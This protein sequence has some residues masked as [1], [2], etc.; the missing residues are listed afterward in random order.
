[1]QNNDAAQRVSHEPDWKFIDDIEQRGKIEYV[2]CDAVH[3]AR[4][5]GAVAMAAEIECVN[6]V[7]LAQ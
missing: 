6:V 3:G 7:V 2:L 5:P 1:M 4:R